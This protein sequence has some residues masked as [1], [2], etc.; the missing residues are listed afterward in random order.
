MRPMQASDIARRL[1]AFEGRGAGTDA[2]R[3]AAVWLASEVRAGRRRAALQSFWC[4]PNWALGH[5]WH[6][7]AAIIG[8]LLAVHHGALGGAIVLAALLSVLSDGLSGHSIGRRL[9]RER[10][11]QNV[12]SPPRQRSGDGGGREAPA[13]ASA[14]NT[15]R[16]R[17]IVTA[18]YDAGRT[19][20]AYR[21]WVR[22]PVAR[23]RRLAGDGRCTPGWLGWLV[24]AMLWLLAVAVLRHEGATGT[25]IGVAQLI[26]TAALVIALALLLELA[27]APFGPAAGDNGAGAAVVLA[28]ARAFDA[29]PPS[30]LD[31]EL[32]LQGAGE[33]A[34]TGLRR[35]L[36]ARRAELH[37]T[38]TI[39]LGIAGA[40]AGAPGW[41][42]SDGTLIPLGFL[43]R[44]R[45]L[46][47]QTAAVAPGPGGHV[48]PVR[49]R[50]VSPALPARARGLPALTIGLRDRRG[51]APRSHQAGDRIE[52]LD[53]EAIDALLQFALTLVDAID[54]DL[55]R[56]SPIDQLHSQQLR[57]GHERVT[58]STQRVDDVRE[59]GQGL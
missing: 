25:P 52:A 1:A 35:H 9:T 22:A 8:S 19:G 2:E 3:R 26:P 23:L 38:D 6:T 12:I 58:A 30:R 16:I 32:V 50:G 28:L 37:A 53:P 29:A 41:W 49:G 42:V 27:G 47:A 17:L 48:A 39:V 21:D 34:M 55:A 14:D 57:D 31:V 40:A 7:L 18:N 15:R 44:L 59:S 11:S 13:G 56:R 33:A 36:R 20:L 24:I 10:A 45:R 4:R 54:A 46:A 5:A 43:P 51:L